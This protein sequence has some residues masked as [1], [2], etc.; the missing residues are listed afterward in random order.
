MCTL[1]HK[2]GAM[3]GLDA[4]IA[5]A[6]F[7]ALSVISGAALYGAIQEA[8]LVAII[9]EANEIA[10][11]VE[12]YKLDTGVDLPSIAGNDT[13]NA[14]GLISDNG[15]TG[16]NPPYVSYDAHTNC[17]CL[18][19]GKFDFICVESLKETPF[20]TTDSSDRECKKVSQFCNY[21][22]ALDLKSNAETLKALETKIDGTATPGASNMDG[23]FI[24][25]LSNGYSAINVK[26]SYDKSQSAN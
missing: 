16:V 26:V 9:A 15:V 11:A 20:A 23:N 1:K 10:K 4:R 13:V 3:F 24:Y 2:K 18:K 19:N 8:K 7:G 21:W 22:I 14:T 5:L 17:Y 6:I 12:S 25:I